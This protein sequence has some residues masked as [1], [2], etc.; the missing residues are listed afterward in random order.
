M[1]SDKKKAMFGPV[2]SKCGNMARFGRSTNGG[3][4][5]NRSDGLAC[6]RE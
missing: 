4:T 2:G 3:V 5:T 6:E 1:G